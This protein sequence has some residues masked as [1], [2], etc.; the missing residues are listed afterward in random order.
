MDV[1]S[2][3]TAAAFLVAMI[4]FGVGWIK[5]GEPVS[6]SPP[7]LPGEVGSGISAWNLNRVPCGFFRRW[8]L[9]PA[10]FLVG[11]YMMPLFL[12]AMGWTEPG[13]V[14]IGM[15]TLWGTI[16]MQCF[17]TAV[18]VGI[19]LPRRKVSDW[20]GLSW[21]GWPWIFVLAPLGW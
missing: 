10:G 11:I 1:E 13:K 20:L 2:Y 21:R 19:V 7:P 5:R 15:Q 17:M 9:I 6:A 14:E 12:T 16:V 18:I 3:M 8:D 4:A